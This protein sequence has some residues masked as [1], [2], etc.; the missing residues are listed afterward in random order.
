MANGTLP[1]ALPMVKIGSD[2]FWDGGLVSTTPLRHLLNNAGSDRLLVFQVDLFNTHAALPRD[3]QDVA[4]RQKAIQYPSRTR[5]VTNYFM[6]RTRQ[7]ALI[8]ELFTN[9]PDVEL[10]DDHRELKHHL[11]GLPEITIL[12]LTYQ[13][14][15][16][17][18]QAKDHEFSGI[19]MRGHWDSGY[20]DTNRTLQ[21]TQWLRT[22]GSRG[23]MTVRNVHKADQNNNVTGPGAHGPRE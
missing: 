2:Y 1:P 10:S 19:S 5:L 22:S 3:T 8:R 16:Y 14:A 20:R 6:E 9:V 12:H 23:G 11:T 15:V 18:G 4:A 7:Q 17:E 21:H 13:Q